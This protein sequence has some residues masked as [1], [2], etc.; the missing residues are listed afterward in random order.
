MV[1]RAAQWWRQARPKGL[2]PAKIVAGEGGFRLPRFYEY[3]VID[4]KIRQLPK[5]HPIGLGFNGLIEGLFG[6]DFLKFV[7]VGCFQ[8]KAFG[9]RFSGFTDLSPPVLRS[10]LSVDCSP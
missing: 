6:F 9:L 3:V 1:I 8:A 4:H 10:I 5:M 2:G 7:F